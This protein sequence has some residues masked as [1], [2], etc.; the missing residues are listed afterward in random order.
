MTLKEEICR[1]LEISD[2]GYYHW[3]NKIHKPLINFFNKYFTKKDFEELNI[4]ILHQ[5][6]HYLIFIFL[7]KVKFKTRN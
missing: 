4:F 7:L 2:S 6:L 1:F 5:Q 3:K